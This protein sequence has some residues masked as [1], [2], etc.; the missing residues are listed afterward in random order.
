[1]RQHDSLGSAGGPG[2]VHDDGRVVGGRSVLV[3]AVV[4]APA[5]VV[6]VRGLPSSQHHAAERNYGHV[7]SAVTKNRHILLNYCQKSLLP[8]VVRVCRLQLVLHVD[9]VRDGRHGRQQ[10]AEARQQIVR[11]HHNFSLVFGKKK[12]N[13]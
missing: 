12:K 6:V 1:M 11:G 7:A 3:A 10:V 8:K 9:D 13:N 5:V 4:V 2:S